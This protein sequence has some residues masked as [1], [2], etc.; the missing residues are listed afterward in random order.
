M[1]NEVADKPLADPM[2]EAAAGIFHAHRYFMHSFGHY[3]LV[4]ARKEILCYRKSAYEM[5]DFAI[6]TVMRLHDTR[7]L[8]L[9]DGAENKRPPGLD[10]HKIVGWPLQDVFLET[11]VQIIFKFT[12][13]FC[14]NKH[15]AHGKALHS[16]RLS[17]INK[18]LAARGVVREIIRQVNYLN[19]VKAVR[20]Q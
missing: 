11:M 3:G 1:K 2:L 5:V 16:I 20:R 10:V 7:R 9:W 12:Q 18:P 13:G 17:A 4:E 15:G 14:P 8:Y 6:L 19:E